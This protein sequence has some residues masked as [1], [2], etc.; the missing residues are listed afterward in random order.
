MCAFDVDWAQFARWLEAHTEDHEHM[1]HDIN[2]DA[3][4]MREE[5]IDP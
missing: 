5:R 4:A 3:Q 2:E 1:H